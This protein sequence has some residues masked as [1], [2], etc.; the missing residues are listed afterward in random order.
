MAKKKKNR[1]LMRTAILLVM[2]GAITFTIYNG[3]T[4]EKSELLE[5]GDQAPDF[6]L[7]DLNG[8]RQQLSDYKGQGVFVNFWGTWCKPCEKEF[9][10]MEKQYQVYK[11]KGVQILAVNIAQSDYE[12]EQYAERKNLTFPI[13]I[14]KNKSVMEAYNIRPLPTTILV[15]PDGEIEKIVTGEMSEEDI[16]SYMEQIKPAEF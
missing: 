12:V 3:V 4:K 10:L 6:A 13:V 1:L 14:D 16:R 5:V 15:N 11:E 8:E 9:P 2:I 7:T